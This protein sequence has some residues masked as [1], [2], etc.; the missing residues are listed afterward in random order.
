MEP[1][2]PTSDDE[3][4]EAAFDA[5]TDIAPVLVAWNWTGFRPA[6]MDGALREDAPEGESWVRSSLP[7][8]LFPFGPPLDDRLQPHRRVRSDVP[9]RH[10]TARWVPGFAP[11]RRVF[12]RSR[13]TRGAR[14]P[15]T[16]LVAP[17]PFVLEPLLPNSSIPPGTPRAVHTRLE[18]RAGTRDIPAAWR[19]HRCSSRQAWS[20]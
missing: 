2:L 15:S 19:R 16:I 18:S 12:A 17:G 7:I 20:R 14:I 1:L 10:D 3:P 8:T 5:L 11:R 9:R 6:L 13:R 4:D